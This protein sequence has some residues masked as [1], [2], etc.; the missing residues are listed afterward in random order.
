ML[1]RSC[2]FGMV[3]IWQ[4]YRGAAGPLRDPSDLRWA[5]GGLGFIADVPINN[6]QRPAVV[7]DPSEVRSVKRTRVAK[8]ADVRAGFGKPA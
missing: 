6:A 1:R 4:P 2:R 5:G 7:T 8:A 3:L